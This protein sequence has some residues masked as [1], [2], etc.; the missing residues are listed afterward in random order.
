MSIFLSLFPPVK[1]KQLYFIITWCVFFSLFK[2]SFCIGKNPVLI[3]CFSFTLMLL[4]HLTTLGQRTSKVFFFPMPSNSAEPAGCPTPELTYDTVDLET[5]SDSTSEGLRPT[6][7]PLF[8]CQLQAPIVTYVSDQLD[9]DHDP[10]LRF[11]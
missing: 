6:S 3:L 5:A 9:S 7:L 11:N 4:P 1:C 10:L 8:R 2:V